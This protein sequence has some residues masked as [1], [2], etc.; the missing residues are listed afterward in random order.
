MRTELLVEIFP[1]RDEFSV[2]IPEIDVQHKRMVRFINDLQAAMLGGQ[3]DD[4]LQ[5][6]FDELFQY[7]QTHF[8]LEEGLMSQAGYPALAR[9]RKEHKRLARNAGALRDKYLGSKLGISLEMLEF[10]RQWLDSHI[11]EYDQA[12]VG[13][14]A[15][16]L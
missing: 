5:S 16:K 15:P 11:M 8:V 1:W 12:Y 7:V 2:G 4:A 10:L 9:H 3:G 14:L 6:I 13:W